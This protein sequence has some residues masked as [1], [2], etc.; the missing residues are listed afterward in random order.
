MPHL[1]SHAHSRTNHSGHSNRTECLTRLGSNP[2]QIAIEN[3]GFCGK[4]Q[5]EG[6]LGRKTTE[7]CENNRNHVSK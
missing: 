5:G 7:I 3:E 6:I 1:E 2:H 4:K